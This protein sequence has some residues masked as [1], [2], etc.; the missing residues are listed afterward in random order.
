MKGLILSFI[1]KQNT[2][3][4]LMNWVNKRHFGVKNLKLPAENDI[5]CTV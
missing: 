2:W 3:H 4:H 5:H 1:L